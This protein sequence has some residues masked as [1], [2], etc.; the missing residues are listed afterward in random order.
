MKMK[1]KMR[2]RYYTQLDIHYSPLG[3]HQKACHGSNLEAQSSI[4]AATNHN[5][6]NQNLE[7]RAANLCLI[8]CF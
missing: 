8:Q 5:N 7:S 4:F 1:M 6:M 2:T 3:P